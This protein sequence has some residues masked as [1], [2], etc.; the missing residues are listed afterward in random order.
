[1]ELCRTADII[2]SAAGAAGVIDRR[3]WAG[4]RPLWTSA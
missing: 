2:I 1:M 3:T 4:D